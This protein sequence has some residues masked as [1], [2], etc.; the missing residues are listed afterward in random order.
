M[1]TEEQI[2]FE[3]KIRLNQ[4]WL[5]KLMYAYKKQN[6]LLKKLLKLKREDIENE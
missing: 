3:K 2:L 1:K 5:A 6:I 4:W